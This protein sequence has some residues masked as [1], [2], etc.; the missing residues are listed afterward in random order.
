MHTHVQGVEHGRNS[1]WINTFHLSARM[2]HNQFTNHT[3]TITAHP[4]AHHRHPT[5]L[6]STDNS[7]A[8]TSSPPPHPHP[9]PQD[10]TASSTPLVY[11]G[12]I[13][14]MDGTLSVSCIDY[15][16]MRE[17]IGIPTGDLFTV[18][19]SWT[20]GSRIKKSM[21]TILEI[22]AVAA[23]QSEAMP[24]LFE[25]LSYL[26]Q[27]PTLRIGLVTRNTP[28]S[29]DAFFNAIGNEWRDVFDIMLTRE[30]PHVKP[31]KRSL[32]YFARQWNIP[33]Y[34]LLM[35]G[36]STE[37]VETGNAAGTATCL[38]AGGGNETSVGAAAAAP[39]PGA[40]PTFAVLS[41]HEL[42]DRLQRRD[43]ALGW[44]G[45]S[46]GTMS[47][48]SE[49]SDSDFDIATTTTANALPSEMEIDASAPGAPPPGLDFLD[50]LFASEAVEAASCSFPR[51]DGA[52]FGIPPDDHPGSKVLHIQCENGALTKLLF[53][54]G[55]LVVGVDPAPAAATKRGLSA[56]AVQRLDV[57]GALAAAAS[58]VGVF[59]AVVILGSSSGGGGGT[60][61]EE[62]IWKK[63]S[64]REIG[65]V[66]RPR[67]RLC[68]D[69][70]IEAGRGEGEI[71]QL[72]QS[73][74]FEVTVFEVVATRV[75]GERIK[76]RLIGMKH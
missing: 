1:C 70:E 35:V 3:P 44:G 12:I 53:S 68:M 21:D 26:Q 59:D 43:T 27:C 37:D 24:G 42:L 33:P 56:V 15:G 5:S 40:V 6:S 57:E 41:L 60:K 63:E 34:K 31:D 65:R 71:Q 58:V 73:A 11:D 69:I 66:L 4:H 32:L 25:L 17:S 2:H 28:Q 39:P 8:S 22:E 72:L 16:K 23:A 38:I 51:I 76:V 50:W 46:T 36:D 74:G 47:L 55:L 10:L 20:D 54:A 75:G 29:V 13:F 67:G 61:L 45:Y 18:M 9:P 52:R 62:Q 64:L 19:E 7:A 14:D 49:D 48:S 30:H